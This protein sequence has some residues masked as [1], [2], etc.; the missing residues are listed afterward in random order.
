MSLSLLLGCSGEIGGMTSLPNLN[1]SA[2]SDD[3]GNPNVD[4]RTDFGGLGKDSLSTHD[5][6]SSR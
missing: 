1:Q 3:L 2:P 5:S 4:S 6:I